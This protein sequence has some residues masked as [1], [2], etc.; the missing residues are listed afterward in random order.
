MKTRILLACLLLTVWIGCAKKAEA[1]KIAGY[2]E[3]TGDRQILGFKYPQGW[4]IVQDGSGR[5]TAYSSQDVVERFYDYTVKG[6]DGGRLIV[7]MEKMD[8]LR[9]LDESINRLKNDLSGSG[10]DI[11]EITA[12]S[13]QNVPGTQVHYSGFVDAKNKLEAIVV[14]AVKD[15]FLCTVKYEAFNK[16]FPGYRSVFDTA[17]ATFRFPVSA[18]DMKPEDL[19]KPSTTFKPFENNLIKLSMPDNFN[20]SF[21]QVKTPV[22]FSME[23]KGYRADCTLRIDV[24]PAQKLS[25]EKI[26]EQNAKFY[27]ESSRGEVT[28]DGLKSTFLNYSPAKGI[29]SRVYFMVKNDKI[30]RVIFNYFAEMKAEFLPAFE[31]TIGSITVK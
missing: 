27:K 6:R 13:V 29:N 4:V 11:S 24:M 2:V 19:A 30:Y 14:V 12:K 31:K 1:P 7:S 10:F 21:P 17:L 3:N 26:V 22:E 23:L 9:T 25:I 20:P 15:S 18:K 16:F 5:Y 28:V 8:T